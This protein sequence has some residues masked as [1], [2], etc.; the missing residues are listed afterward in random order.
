MAQH[1]IGDILLN[2]LLMGRADLR[3]PNADI[4]MYQLCMR[5]WHRE[6]STLQA[7]AYRGS[8][9]RFGHTWHIQIL[10]TLCRD[11]QWDRNTGE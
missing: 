2:I 6:E 9:S 10:G 11:S 4:G 1:S 7:M 8:G 3:I 5:S